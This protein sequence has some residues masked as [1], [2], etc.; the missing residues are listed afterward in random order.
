M[1][2]DDIQH[3]IGVNS[4]KSNHEFAGNAAEKQQISTQ[5]GKDGKKLT[6]NDFVVK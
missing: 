3:E 1:I 5:H 4:F 6:L 2:R